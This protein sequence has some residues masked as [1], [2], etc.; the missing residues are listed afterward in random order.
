MKEYTG[1]LFDLYPHPKNG[2]IVWL[3]GEDE[4]PR[5]F[6]QPFQITFYARG[7]T[8]RLRQLWK[9]LKTQA[10][11]LSYVQRDDLYEGTKDV[12]KISV[13]NPDT[14]QEIFAEVYRRFSDL[15]YHDVDI[16]LILRYAAEFGVFPL[17]HCKV[18]VEQGWKISKITPLGTPWELDPK[19]PDLRVL[20]IQPDIN[21]SH[22]SPKYLT[23]SFDRFKYQLVIHEPRRLL[24][25]L[26]GILRQYDPDVILT[27]YGDT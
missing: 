9:F 2:I 21:P 26:N 16:P 18:E 23:I 25:C 15:L 6:I 14:F 20:H 4:K 11:I 19:L 13:I 22:T 17:A 7:A 5:S 10:V 1:W 24:F 8:H 12:V 27:S 3:A